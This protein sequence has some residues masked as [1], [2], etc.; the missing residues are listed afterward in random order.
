MHQ[1]TKTRRA[2]ICASGIISL[3]TLEPAIAADPSVKLR[4]SVGSSW[5]ARNDVQIPNTDLGTRFSLQEAAGSGPTPYAR[6][7]LN[8]TINEKHG[9]RVLLAPLSYTETVM[10]E[11]DVRF[12]G[13][14]FGSNQSTDATYRFNSWRL[15]Y[16]YSL[17]QND[18]ASVRIGATLKVRD[19]EIRL[20]QGDTV[21]FDD[22]VGIVPLLYLAGDY[23]LGNRWALR[24]DFD[25][26]A[27]GPGRAIDVG[28]ALEYSIARQWQ[29][30]AEVRVLDGGAD[31]EDV[32]NFARFNSTAIAISTAF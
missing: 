32:Y 15:G 24:A 9:V 27:G 18:A 28:V 11:Q 23:R 4:L 16:H 10:F 13:A 21:S 31:T 6:F 22:D 26:L 12:A 20:T 25:G 8:W 14:S 2:A 7:E 5:Q 19:A 3:L 30:G 17:M 29:I 1:V